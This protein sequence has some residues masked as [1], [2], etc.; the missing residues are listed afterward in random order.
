MNPGSVILSG[1]MMFRYLGWT[2]A[3]DAIEAA[4]EKTIGQKRVTYDF[5][6]QMEGATV[7]HDVRV[8][9]GAHREP[10]RGAPTASGSQRLDRKTLAALLAVLAV[11]GLLRF[12]SLSWGLRHLPLRDESVFVDN[13]VRMVQEKDWDQRFYE[14]PGLFFDILRPAFSL[15]PEDALSSARPYLVAR[16]VVAAFGVASIGLVFL[17]GARLV[18]PRAGLVAAL[19]SAVS[20]IEVITAHRVRPDVVLETFALLALWSFASQ[21]SATLADVRSPASPSARPPPSSS[22][23]SCSS[24]RT[25]SHAC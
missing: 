19:L 4:L 6:R 21:S 15:I 2:E 3:A 23:A 1:C 5:A 16:S 24:L 12:W 11:A 25:S 17:I 7:L 8:R 10:V 13:V 22:P 18:S 20:P 14:Y 9:L